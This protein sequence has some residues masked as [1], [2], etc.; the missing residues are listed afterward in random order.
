MG[1]WANPRKPGK[2]S[3]K[4]LCIKLGHKYDKPVRTFKQWEE[5]MIFV[6]LHKS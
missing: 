4:R 6:R 3:L 2:C 5:S 1:P